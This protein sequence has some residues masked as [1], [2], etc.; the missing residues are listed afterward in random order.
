MKS[1]CS[2][3]NYTKG[4]ILKVKEMMIETFDTFEYVICGNC[5]SIY[6]ARPLKLEEISKY[7]P[8]EY[9]SFSKNIS[10][11]KFL[12]KFFYSKR[13]RYF[14]FHDSFIGKILSELQPLHGLS[15]LKYS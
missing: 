15:W 9:Y 8:K 3:C 11:A 12:K 4:E 6:I 5:Q 7:Y 14:L 2:I 10:E 13:M 1:I